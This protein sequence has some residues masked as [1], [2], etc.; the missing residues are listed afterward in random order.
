MEKSGKLVRSFIV[1]ILTLL[2]IG[3]FLRGHSLSEM[4]WQIYAPGAAL[5][6]F[7]NVYLLPRFKK[8]KEE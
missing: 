2:V 6:A 3:Y 1:T 7:F 8:G 4:P 5:I